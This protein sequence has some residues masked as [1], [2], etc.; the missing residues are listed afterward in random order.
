MISLELFEKS[1]LK[2]GHT[3]DFR[4]IVKDDVNKILKILNSWLIISQ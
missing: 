4:K 1:I 3:C 2:E